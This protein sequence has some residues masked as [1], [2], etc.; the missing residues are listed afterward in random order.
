MNYPKKSIRAYA[1]INLSL[2]IA[3]RRDDG[4]HLLKSI[5]QSVSLYDKVTVE[6]TDGDSIEVST[7]LSYLA[8]DRRNIAYLAAE[9][10]LSELNKK[11]GIKIDIEK[12]IPMGA[13]L[14]GGSADAAATLFALNG[15]YGSPLGKEKLL[16]IGLR[17][18]A[19]V[20]FCMTGG[21]CLAEGLGEILTPLS[22][23]PDCH[24][25]IVKPKMSINT[26]SAFADYDKTVSTMHPK[27]D[28]IIK[29]LDSGNLHEISVRL[30]N[31]LENAVAPYYKELNKYKGIMLECG[32]LGSVM[33]GSGSAVFGIFTDSE[34]AEKAKKKFSRMKIASFLT[35]PVND[36][37]AGE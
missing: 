18:G 31:V 32:A 16:E 14:A 8:T 23:L 12:N 19:D 3:G 20:P 21:T 13:G 11:D 27:T 17:C 29:C 1:K 6:K 25:L 4:Y 34:K 15:I 2:D 9:Y 33:T 28:E 10:F 30:Y 36:I 22:P 37:I 7:N 5:M 35:V 26:K 24:I